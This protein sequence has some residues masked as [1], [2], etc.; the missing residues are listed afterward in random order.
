MAIRS[1]DGT[2]LTA[3]DLKGPAPAPEPGWFQPG[4]KSEAA[5]R[6]FSNAATLG[7]GK[8]LQA[9]IN[10]AISGDPNKS[11]WDNIKAATSGEVGA[12][13]AAAEAH[14]VAYG[15]G[16]V[17]GA[18]PMG[19]AGAGK[20]LGTQMATQGG[21]SGL[22]TLADTQDLGEAAKSA[23]I[24]AALP[25]AGALAGKVAKSVPN[26]VEWA[27]NKVGA[28]GIANKQIGNS[29]NDLAQVAQ[30]PEREIIM[31]KMA[32][33]G[34]PRKMDVKEL[35]TMSMTGKKGEDIEALA[36]PRWAVLRDTLLK[37]QPSPMSSIISAHGKVALGVGVGATAGGSMMGP[38]GAAL[39]GVAGGLYG[40]AGAAKQAL[41]N[42]AARKALSPAAQAGE[43]VISDAVAKASNNIGGG[44]T[45]AGKFAA[46]TGA[47]NQTSPEARAAMNE[48]N[49]LNDEDSK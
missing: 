9:P 37:D 5:A 22:T 49:P 31:D 8:Y 14:P 35:K 48:D 21:M 26:V 4:S 20:A 19:M 29:L 16:A 41:V 34:I 40:A 36:E 39:G 15:A 25:G 44:I 24:G 13:Q 28:P 46:I 23:T 1:E 6:G 47:L 17:A 12:N 42:R 7:L 18:L 32:S 10:A 30:G 33:S 43:K 2:E 11:Y 38:G 45:N 27:S 3:E